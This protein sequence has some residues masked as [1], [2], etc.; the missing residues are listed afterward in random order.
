[1]TEPYDGDDGFEI[2]EDEQSVMSYKWKIPKTSNQEEGDHCLRASIIGVDVDM[3]AIVSATFFPKE[4]TGFGS[5]QGHRLMMVNKKSKVIQTDL[6]NSL[7]PKTAR[8]AA[9]EQNGFVD[10]PFAGFKTK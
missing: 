8:G 4:S 10:N 6:W 2:D 3:N 5:K 1:M 7:S 9:L